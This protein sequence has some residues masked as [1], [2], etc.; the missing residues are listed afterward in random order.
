MCSCPRLVWQA[1]LGRVLFPTFRMMKATELMGIFRTT[2]SFVSELSWSTILPPHSGDFILVYL[3]NMCVLWFFFSWNCS[4]MK[5]EGVNG[6]LNMKITR[7]YKSELVSM[8]LPLSEKW[9]PAIF[10]YVPRRSQFY[11]TTHTIFNF[12]NLL[13]EFNYLIEGLWTLLGMKK[14]LSYPRI[15]SIHQII[16]CAN[17]NKL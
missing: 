14:T 3:K 5:C 11:K 10:W 16:I 13:T 4:K 17:H 8:F 15:S 1:A 2:E 7:K 12:I 6:N 9:K